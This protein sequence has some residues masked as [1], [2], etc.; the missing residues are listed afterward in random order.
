MVPWHPTVVIA[1]DSFKGSLTAAEVAAAMAEGVRTALGPHAIIVECP[2]A[3]GGEGTLDALLANWHAVPRFIDTTDAVGRTRTA[4]YGISNDGVVGIIEAAEAN[5]LPHVSDIPLQPMHADSYGVGVI[6]RTL[7]DQGVDEIVL[8]I[9]GSA[10]TDGGT[11][12]LRAL[13]TSFLDSDGG[14]VEPGGAGLVRIASVDDSQL[15][16]RARQVRWRVATDVDNPLCGT[17]GAAAVFGP[18]KGATPQNVIDLDVG[19]EHLSRLINAK[20]GVDIAEHPGAGAAGG[21]PACLVPL[22]GAELTPGARLVTDVVG[23]R[24]ICESADAVLTG[25]GSFDSQSLRGKVVRGV[26]DV[27]PPNCPVVVIAG[28]VQLSAA[29]IA[30]SGVLSAF[31]IANGPSNLADMIANSAHLVRE[32]SV[33]VGGLLG[34]AL[35]ARGACR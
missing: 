32:V 18:Q 22:L 13:G 7:L 23:L 35:G 29:E 31:S 27:T 25:E 3:D 26:L 6:A 16:P 11:G 9:G 24:E 19:L 5:G 21:M 34:V 4:R 33:Q 1:P 2:L 8:C 14:E 10:S 20:T 15:H 28:T 17:M 12:L 30:S